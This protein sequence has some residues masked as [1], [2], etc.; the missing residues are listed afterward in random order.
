MSRST[1]ETLA[2]VTVRTLAVL[3]LPF[4]LL[5]MFASWWFAHSGNLLLWSVLLV[6]WVGLLLLRRWAAILVCGL[7]GFCVITDLHDAVGMAMSHSLNHSDT[8]LAVAEFIEMCML[9]ALL[10]FLGPRLHPG[11]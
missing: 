5:Q 3:A 4:S 1:A 8:L 6:C 9:A 11:L 2:V 7:L 10:H